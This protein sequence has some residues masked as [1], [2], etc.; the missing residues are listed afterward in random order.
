MARKEELRKH[1]R[2]IA[3]RDGQAVAFGT[4][5]LCVRGYA[6]GGSR[7]AQGLMCDLKALVGKMWEFLES[8]DPLPF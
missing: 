7:D 8:Q 5:L 1:W 3:E 2:G 4:L 6:R